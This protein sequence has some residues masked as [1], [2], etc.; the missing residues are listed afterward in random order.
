MILQVEKYDV[1]TF[2][3][4]KKMHSLDENTKIQME[5]EKT[6]GPID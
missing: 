4:A 6:S 3:L 1:N 5:T 2:V